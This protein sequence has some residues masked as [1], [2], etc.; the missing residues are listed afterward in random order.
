MFETLASFDDNQLRFIG[1]LVVTFG[2]SFIIGIWNVARWV[3]KVEYDLDNLGEIL[4]TEKGLS[5]ANKRKQ[6]AE[7]KAI[8]ST[9]GGMMKD[10]IKKIWEGHKK[11][12]LTFVIGAILALIASLTGIPLDLLKE[13]AHEASKPSVEAPAIPAPATEA[14]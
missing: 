2:A 6:K 3:A 8:A 10:I 11:K 14:K 7:A 1:T 9:N 4:K 12:I 13:S 5:R